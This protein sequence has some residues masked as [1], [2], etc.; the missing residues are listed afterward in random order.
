M[1]ESDVAAGR[2][3]QPIKATLARNRDVQ[4]T[5]KTGT[6]GDGL[7]LELRDVKHEQLERNV[8]VLKAGPTTTPNA[9][10]QAA[11]ANRLRRR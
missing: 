9:G 8:V 5:M 1:H 6:A 7:G 10:A 3:V 2:A 11:L 4:L